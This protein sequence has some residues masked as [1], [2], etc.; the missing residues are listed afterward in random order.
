M[1]RHQCNRVHATKVLQINRPERAQEKVNPRLVVHEAVDFL[2]N[3]A[4]MVERGGGIMLSP[5]NVGL[6]KSRDTF[7]EC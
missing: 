6:L 7:P 3:H 2:H 5:S 4:T 1:A